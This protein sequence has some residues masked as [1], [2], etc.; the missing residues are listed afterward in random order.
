MM[1][2]AESA[3]PAGGAAPVTATAARTNPKAFLIVELII[4][5][6]WLV[7]RRRWAD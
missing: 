2:T 4:W 1:I 6:C 3:A 5:P 7:L